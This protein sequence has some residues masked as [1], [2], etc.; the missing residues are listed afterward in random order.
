M[1]RLI[2]LIL[3][4][5]AAGLTACETAPQSAEKTPSE[6]SQTGAL[7]LDSAQW[8]Q[9]R[10][11][12]GQGEIT[13]LSEEIPAQG[14]VDVPPQNLAS[15][16]AKMGGFVRK[17]DI[18]PGSRVVKGQ[19]L[20]VLEHPDY[21]RLQ[22]QYLEAW[23]KLNYLSKEENRQSQ[24]AQDQAVASKKAESAVSERNMMQANL[25]GLAAQLDMMGLSPQD[26]LK[27]G[28]QRDVAIK[29]PLNGFVKSVNVNLGSYAD[30]ATPLFEII[31]KEHMHIELKVF[32]N[33]AMRVKEGQEIRFTVQGS[34]QEYEAEVFLVGKVLEGENRTVNVHG[35]MHPEPQELMPG[36]YVQA[37]I[38]TA[39]RQVY[40]LPE[41]AVVQHNKQSLVFI[42]RQK[43]G[44]GFIFEPRVI[45]TGQRSQGRIEW[46]QPDTQATVVVK[47]AYYLLA[48]LKASEE[49]DEI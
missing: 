8:Q 46:L 36:L 38:L 4:G 48:R 29:S 10:M 47:N 28:I 5:F 34:E 18:Y 45:R 14:M 1:K 33:Q 41:A 12:L 7:H 2:L 6:E 13:P 32:E 37:R 19:V 31:N 40:T 11:A 15:V 20:C 26:V 16:T 49:G 42:Q 9:S 21:I 3:L 22:Q 25:A 30:P 43:A 27:K 23:Q 44:K 39:P 17:L 35:H 24:L